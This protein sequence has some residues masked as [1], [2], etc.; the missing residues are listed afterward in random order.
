[1]RLVCLM[2]YSLGLLCLVF[3]VQAQ[4]VCTVFCSAE[5][6]HSLIEAYYENS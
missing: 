5:M 3:G 6:L 4:H 2:V 1:M